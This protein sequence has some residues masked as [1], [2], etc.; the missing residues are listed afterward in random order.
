MAARNSN[1][2]P[3]AP[4]TPSTA[5][6]AVRIGTADGRAIVGFVGTVVFVDAAPAQG[7]VKARRAGITFRSAA[8]RA[9]TVGVRGGKAY[10]TSVA[11]KAGEVS[12]L[13][14]HLGLAPDS[15]HASLAGDRTWGAF[16]GSVLA[17]TRDQRGIVLTLPAMPS[18][19]GRTT[20][21]TGPKVDATDANVLAT[22]AR[23]MPTA[24]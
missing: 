22:L 2:T 10:Q 6:H 14:A 19:P 8:S 16:V 9:A 21:A 15:T 13:L 17:G 24:S 3:R 1:S 20:R 11:L 12:A 23:L 5:P 4:R 7:A 18:K